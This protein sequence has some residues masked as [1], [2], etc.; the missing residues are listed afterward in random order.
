MVLIF[1]ASLSISSCQ[2][3]IL[4]EALD[5]F[6]CLLSKNCSRLH[7]TCHV[8]M[9]INTNILTSYTYLQRVEGTQ[10]LEGIRSNLRDLVVTEVSVNRGE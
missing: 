6:K 1:Q 4:G 7:M 10:A 3:E 8:L 9:K 2:A 5:E